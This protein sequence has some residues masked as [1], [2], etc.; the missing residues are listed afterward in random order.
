MSSVNAKRVYVIDYLMMHPCVDCGE[1][2]LIVLE[3]D[4]QRDKKYNIAKLITNNCS[5]KRLV[6][7]IDKCQVR[8]ANCHRRKTAGTH[9]S[10]RLETLEELESRVVLQKSKK[11]S[12]ELADE[13]RAR[14]VRGVYGVSKL[15]K[16]YGA[17]RTTVRDIIA[18]DYYK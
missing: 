12:K 5:L 11:L 15:A 17:C 1:T 10:Y 9:G 18:G 7:E 4:H 13:I 14:Y 16:E 3:F 6:L 2:D 8:C